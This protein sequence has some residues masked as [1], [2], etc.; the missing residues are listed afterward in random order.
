MVRHLTIWLTWA[1]VSTLVM[2]TSVAQAAEVGAVASGKYRNLFREIGKSDAE[3]RAKLDAAWQQ[4]FFGD[5]GEQR[6]YYPV[7]ADKGYILDVNNNDVRTEGMSYGMMIAV[8]LDKREEF[9]RLWTWAKTHMQHRDGARKGYFAWK[10]KPT[11]EHLDP[12]P[13][14]DGEEYFV[15]ALFFAHHRWGSDRGGIYDYRSEAN[16]ILHTMLHKEEDNGGVVDGITNMFDPTYKQVVFVP[17]GDAAKFTDASYHLPAFYELWARWAEEDNDF[18]R[19]AARAS[20]DLLRKAAHPRTGLAP[21]YSTF[22]GEPTAP[23]WNTNAIHFRHDAWRV[24]QN[25]AMDHAW[26]G[27]EPSQVE[28]SNR[29]L[30]FFASQGPQYM[31]LYALEGRPLPENNWPASPGLIGMNAAAALAANDASAPSF[32]E[33]LWEAP[34][35]D[36]RYR[37]Y[38]SMLYMF[39]LLHASGNF[40]IYGPTP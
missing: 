9:D 32:V 26:F 21:D 25:I 16:A 33:A 3:I 40:R 15:T 22:D 14:S 5:D 28:Q 24:A 7:G 13:A 17:I 8:Q 6:V 23:T 20:R 11:G 27:V 30:R 1:V 4:L 2:L 38:D 36:G 35:P 37:Y 29:L 39:G 10:C 18:W 31:Q 34:I 19:D 12:N